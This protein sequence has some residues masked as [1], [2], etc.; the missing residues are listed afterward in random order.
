MFISK[1]NFLVQS[2]NVFENIC[3]LDAIIATKYSFCYEFNTANYAVITFH[4][5]SFKKI[6]SES[7]DFRIKTV[8]ENRQLFEILIA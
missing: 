8:T 3:N 1:L 5:Y 7:F 4:I 6:Y 2:L